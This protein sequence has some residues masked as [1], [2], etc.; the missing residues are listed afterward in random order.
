MIKYDL[1]ISFMENFYKE[2]YW[3]NSEINAKNF[4]RNEK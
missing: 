4:K 1:T 3:N 2:V